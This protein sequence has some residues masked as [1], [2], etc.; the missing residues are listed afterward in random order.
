VFISMS[1][2]GLPGLNGFTGEF[3]SLAG[4]FKAKPIYSMLG[5]IG[6]VLGAWYLLTAVQKVFFGQ[7][8]EPH[9]GHEEDEVEDMS[10]REFVSLLPLAALC[11]WIG[12]KP[13]VVVDIIEPDVK[14]VVDVLDQHRGLATPLWSTP[15][16]AV[17]APAEAP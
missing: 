14:A 2:I 16:A 11:L 8:R 10:A 5:T 15:V 4:M 3:L 13:S 9:H 7:L 1:S 17:R 12:V 6:V